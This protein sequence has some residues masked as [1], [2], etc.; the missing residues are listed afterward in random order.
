MKIKNIVLRRKGWLIAPL[1]GTVLLTAIVC[2]LLPNTYK[3]TATILIQNQQIP[4][5]L[6]PSTITSYAQ[7][8]IQSI[9]QEVTSRSKLLNLADKYRLLPE[10]RE[11][12]TTEEFVEKI[13]KR[14]SLQTINAEVNPDRGGQPIQMTIAFSLSYEDESPKTSQAVTNEISSFFMEKN[15]ESRTKHARGTTEFLQ[16]QLN[17]EKEH[18]DELQTRLAEYRQTHLEKLPEYASLNMQKLEKLNAGISEI[19]MQL[20]SLEEQRTTLRSNMTLLDPYSGG[21]RGLS[22]SDRLQQA[23]LELAN[24]LSKYSEA[25]PAVAAKKQEIDLLESEGAT[26]SS[27]LESDAQLAELEAK[28]AALRAKYSEKH[29][30]VKSTLQEIERVRR[31][32]AV[33][34]G[35][36]RRAAKRD[37]RP[38]NPAYV[39]IQAD[40]DKIGVSISSLKAEKKRLEA[41]MKEVYDKLHAMPEVA[42]GFQDLDTEYQLARAHF[43]EIQQKLLAA[44]VSQGM[45]EEQLG[46]SFQVI[47]PAFLPEKPFKPNRIAIM[48][49]GVVLGCG[50]AVGAAALKEFSDRSIR[51]AESLESLTSLRV[52]S[53][54]PRIVTAEDIVARSRRRRVVAAAGLCCIVGTVLAFH[55][56]IMDLDVFYAKVERVVMRKIP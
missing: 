6:V 11:K 55:F 56:L 45:E 43:A 36:S 46:E 27:T 49:I 16:E 42:K 26:R 53:T 38:S 54:I 44:K 4:S 18:I 48:L 29:P 31:E 23:R 34:A 33:G 39:G 24:L 5:T 10:K 47:E 13:R 51:D 1:F 8:R 30:S 37:S 25:H 20:R 17:L 35:E 28:L 7:Q 12:L 2:I 14:I 32:A 19:N 9:S 22:P 3:S 52:I 41:Q 50:F 40:M 15:V 21:G